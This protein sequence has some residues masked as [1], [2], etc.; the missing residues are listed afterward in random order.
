[1]DL[2][3][4]DL[5]FAFLL[6]KRAIQIS[7]GSLSGR[8]WCP[9]CVT[10]EP[11]VQKKFDDAKFDT[12]AVLLYVGVGPRPCKTFLYRTTLILAKSSIG[13]TR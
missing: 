11:I 2:D 13:G 8:S 10:A 9:D 12:D 7:N 6:L 3:L 1:M 4:L 5:G